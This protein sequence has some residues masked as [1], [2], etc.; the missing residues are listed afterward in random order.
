MA[1]LPSSVALRPPRAGAAALGILWSSPPRRSPLSWGFTWAGR[2]APP[3]P[4]FISVPEPL[5]W[6]ESDSPKGPHADL[7][8][9]LWGGLLAEM[10]SVSLRGSGRFW[11]H[12]VREAPRTVPR[13]RRLCASVGHP[14]PLES[15]G[16]PVGEK[17][18]PVL[19]PLAVWASSSRGLVHPGA[20]APCFIHGHTHTCPPRSLTRSQSVTLPCTVTSSLLSQAR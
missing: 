15:L 5:R 12:G 4:V 7:Y 18:P 19:R 11:C 10:F 17:G 16:L 14:S 13:G 20:C 9:P 3:L 8:G 6:G 1:C 2:A